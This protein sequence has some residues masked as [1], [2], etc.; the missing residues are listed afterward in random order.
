[1]RIFHAIR[2]CEE[3][4]MENAQLRKEVEELRAKLKQAKAET[5][6]KYRKIGNLISDN[7]RLIKVNAYLAE[8]LGRNPRRRRVD[9]HGDIIKQEQQ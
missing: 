7:G 6:D 5:E 8:E 1:M 4:T 9:D 3:L 2:R